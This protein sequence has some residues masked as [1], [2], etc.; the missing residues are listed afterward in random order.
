[1]F[2]KELA[3]VFDWIADKEEEDKKVNINPISH[4]RFLYSE[5]LY[6]NGKDNL[7]WTRL[8]PDLH[9]KVGRI[10][11]LDGGMRIVTCNGKK[12]ENSKF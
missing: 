2:R 7:Y 9:F 6:T 8:D 11:I 3:S 12:V 10:W 4:V 5:S 1:M